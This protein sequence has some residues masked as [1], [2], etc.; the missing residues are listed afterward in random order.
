MKQTSILNK[1]NEQKA[2]DTFLIVGN[3]FVYELLI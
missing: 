1:P 2:T 3:A